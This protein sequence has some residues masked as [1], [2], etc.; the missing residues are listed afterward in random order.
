[1]NLTAARHHTAH[2]PSRS[3]GW[4][5]ALSLLLHLMV[6]LGMQREQEQVLF[7]AAQTRTAALALHLR[8]PEPAA[9]A[10]PA[11]TTP[12]ASE[13][14]TTPLQPGHRSVRPEQQQ[15]EP[16]TQTKQAN[17]QKTAIN[18][19][20]IT[21]EAHPDS[22]ARLENLRV[23]LQRELTHYF[24]YPILARRNG[25]QGEV[26][27][28]FRL[29]VDGTIMNAR[30]ARSSGYGVLDRAALNALGKVKRINHTLQQ[31]QDMQL[32]VIYRLQES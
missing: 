5:I 12:Q 1:M 19:E 10:K 31:V 2:K 26:I 22:T 11:Q 32:P 13:T 4:F 20:T 8:Q 30:V 25:W 3:M 17:T 24:N 6:L 9:A 23:T 14:V 27:L 16:K 15:P 28:A 18:T 29:E 7:P 21:A